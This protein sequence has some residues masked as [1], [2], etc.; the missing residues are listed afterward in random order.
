MKQWQCAMCGFIYDERA[1][2]PEDGLAPATPW[3]DVP[4]TWTCPDCSANKSDFTPIEP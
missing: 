3:T 2:R 1:G 4:D